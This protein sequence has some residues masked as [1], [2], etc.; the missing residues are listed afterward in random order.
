MVL[1]S[2]TAQVVI[3]CPCRGAREAYR[4]AADW[5]HTGTLSSRPRMLSMHADARRA[6]S[7]ARCGTGGHHVGRPHR[8]ARARGLCRGRSDLQP[9]G[10]AHQRAAGRGD[11]VPRCSR[12]GRP[13]R[14]QGR[15]V[16]MAGR[17]RPLRVA[18][19]APGRRGGGAGPESGGE[20]RAVCCAR[21]WRAAR[22]AG[23]E[24][25][26]ATEPN[27][28][29]PGVESEQQSAPCMSLFPTFMWPMIL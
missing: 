12:H 11:D 6:R 10:Q 27:L 4:D 19:A 17:R 15:Q 20:W 28:S 25:C 29:G 18:G 26:A 1:C 8:A 13:R 16:H 24:I 3:I 7:G 2:T 22:C 14:W 21:R 9:C 23:C 5:P